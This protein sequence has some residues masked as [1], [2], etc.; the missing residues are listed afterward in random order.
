MLCA[1]VRTNT[2]EFFYEVKGKQGW[3]A[4]VTN[5]FAGSNPVP[6]E[7]VV[8]LTPL[9]RAVDSFC[10]TAVMVATF[11]SGT[12]GGMAAMTLLQVYLFNINSWSNSSG[13][14][15]TIYAPVA[16]RVNRLYWI[17]IVLALASAV[18]RCEFVL[19]QQCRC[20]LITEFL[21]PLT[22]LAEFSC[23]DVDAVPTPVHLVQ[24]QH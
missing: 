7:C 14:L 10:N 5:R 11:V 3:L 4:N 23:I 20:M 1:Q 24:S 18:S 2:R 13:V 15:L 12:L 19:H 16:L 9:E 8:N 21:W 6:A 22:V 17:L